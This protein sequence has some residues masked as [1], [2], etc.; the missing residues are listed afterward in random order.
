MHTFPLAGTALASSYSPS[1]LSSRIIIIII[2]PNYYHYRFHSILRP[3][4]PLFLFLFS[5][6]FEQMWKGVMVGLGKE[7]GI[8]L[9]LGLG[10]GFR[11]STG[12]GEI[13]A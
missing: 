2:M 3:Y 4:L 10:L 11:K 12:R 8:G 13:W 9:G 7:V 5:L 6:S 1:S